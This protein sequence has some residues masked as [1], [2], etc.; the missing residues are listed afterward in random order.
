MPTFPVKAIEV[1]GRGVLKAE[2]VVVDKDN[3]VYGGGRNGI[4]YKG[5]ARRGG[6]QTGETA[7]RFNSQWRHHGPQW[8]HYLLR[9]RQGSGD[10]RYAK[11]PCFDG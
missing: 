6:E 8:R 1:F 10:A 9:S 3:C 5:D 11:W 2:G 7:G 4:I